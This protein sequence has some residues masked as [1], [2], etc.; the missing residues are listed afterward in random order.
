MSDT[1]KNDT[2]SPG[3]SSRAAKL[4][5]FT[6]AM[7]N[8]SAIVSLRGLPAETTYGLSSAFYYIFAALFFLL[9]KDEPAGDD[10]AR[11]TGAAIQT[12]AP[13]TTAPPET[14]PV[15]T[16]PA[17]TAEPPETSGQSLPS[18]SDSESEALTD[19]AKPRTGG[20]S[21]IITLLIAVLALGAGFLTGY[22][23]WM[24]R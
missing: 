11:D 7:I 15:T 18:G 6:L 10:P 23:R 19:P 5:V 24:R 16:P 21:W 22:V 2:K 20:V 13:E 14:D 8:V 1:M 9:R 3:G 17:T 12:E 4:G